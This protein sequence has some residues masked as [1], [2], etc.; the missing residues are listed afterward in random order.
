MGNNGM[1]ILHAPTT[2]PAES[3]QTETTKSIIQ[4]QKLIGYC[5]Q[6]GKGRCSQEWVRQYNKY[7]KKDGE[8]WATTTITQIWHFLYEQWKQR[9]EKLHDNNDD[10]SITKLNALLSLEPK[11][12]A[13]FDQKDQLIDNIDQQV[14]THPIQTISRQPIRFQKDWIKRTESFVK[15]GI[16]RAKIRIKQRTH[17]ITNYFT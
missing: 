8:K 3:L 12:Q 7:Y 16:K 15:D 1:S 17:S 5:D 6:L 4:Q 13:I 10:N 11:I 9:Y 14:F 2:S